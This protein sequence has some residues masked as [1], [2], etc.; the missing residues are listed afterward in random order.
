MPTPFTGKWPVVKFLLSW[1]GEEK[2]FTVRYLLDT[3]LTSFLISDVFVEMFFVPKVKGDVPV[4]IFDSEDKLVSGAEQ[5]FTHLLR[6]QYNCNG[7][8]TGFGSRR[9]RRELADERGRGSA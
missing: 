7:Q 6:F 2:I 4:P 9:H 5:A 1:N 3:G 8:G